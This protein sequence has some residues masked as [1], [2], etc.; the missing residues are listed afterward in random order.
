MASVGAPVT[1]VLSSHD[2]VRPVTRYG[3][4]PRGERRA[5]A[6]ALLMLA[7]PGAAY[8]Y[9]GEEL[10]LPQAELPDDR[11]RDPLWERSGAPNGGRDG[12]RV[13]LP[14]E[15]DA[16]PYG[17]ST[18]APALLVPPPEGW[19]ARTVGPSR[20]DPGSALALYRAALLLRRQHPSPPGERCGSTVPARGSAS[21]AAP[22]PVRAE[23]RS[24]SPG[25][26]RRGP[27]S[28]GQHRVHRAGHPPGHRRVDIPHPREEQDVKDVGRTDLAGLVKAYDIRGAV[29]DQLGGGLA[30]AFARGAADRGADATVIGLCSTDQLYFAGG[31][32]RRPGAMITASHNPAPGSSAAGPPRSS[33]LVAEYGRYSDDGLVVPDPD[34]ATA[35]VRRAFVGRDGAVMDTLDGLTVSAKHRWFNLRPSTTESLLRLN[36]EAGDPGTVEA[37]REEVLALIT[38]RA[39]GRAPGGWVPASALHARRRGAHLA[40]PE[41]DR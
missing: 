14:W 16:P 27:R 24:R 6:A 7:L 12:C 26:G 17:F 5:R 34:H 23:V 33:H 30:Q 40:L 15:G 36:V 13:P 18:A 10:G 1:W 37:L 32:L 21:G 29:P 11:L 35:A 39:R 3:G 28:P 4:G 20:H 19:A 31:V 38:A 22:A 41:A 25:A 8:V 9:Q 2:A